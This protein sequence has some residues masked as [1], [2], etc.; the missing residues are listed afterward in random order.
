M[1]CCGVNS[2]TDFSLTHTT[3]WKKPGSSVTSD[4]NAPLVC[5]KTEP[6][7][8][9]GNA[10]FDCARTGSSWDIHENVRTYRILVTITFAALCVEG[11]KSKITTILQS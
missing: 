8:T 3:E 5:C 6:S 1:E 7:T 2:Y 4:L 11:K 9:G 10:A